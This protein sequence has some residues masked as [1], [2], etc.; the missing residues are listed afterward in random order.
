MGGRNLRTLNTICCLPYWI[1]IHE[2]KLVRTGN[3]ERVVFVREYQH[4]IANMTDQRSQSSQ[5]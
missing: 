2:C 1:S 3:W 4:E 5:P